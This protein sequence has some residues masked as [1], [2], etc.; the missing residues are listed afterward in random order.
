MGIKGEQ[1]VKIYGQTPRDVGKFR[2]EFDHYEAD[3]LFP[4]RFLIDKGIES[5]I[6][7]P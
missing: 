6:R 7:I 4:N 2:E 1:L 3:I 5:G